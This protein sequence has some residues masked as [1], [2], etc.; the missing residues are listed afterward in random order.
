MK[1]VRE[2]LPSR[3][4][5]VC[6]RFTCSSRQVRSELRAEK[7]REA[8]RARVIAMTNAMPASDAPR[9]GPLQTGRVS[10]DET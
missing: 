8:E 10:E 7:E 5:R 4:G 6:S 1:K 3:L 2:T 9:V